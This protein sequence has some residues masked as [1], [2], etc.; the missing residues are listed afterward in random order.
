MLGMHSFSRFP[1][2]AGPTGLD[3]VS[4]QDGC[5]FQDHQPRQEHCLPRLDCQRHRLHLLSFG[6]SS[7]WICEYSYQ[8]RVSTSYLPILILMSSTKPLICN[9]TG[10]GKSWLNPPTTELTLLDHQEPPMPGTR[11]VTLDV[12]VLI[13]PDN[14]DNIRQSNIDD[15]TIAGRTELD[16]LPG[17]N[18]ASALLRPQLA[19]SSQLWRNG[20]HLRPRTDSRIRRSGSS[21]GRNRKTLHVR[22]LQ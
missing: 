10:A 4:N 17:R 18:P 6:K 2:A 19:G 16:H 15:M 22:D 3:D 14:I 9:C 21:V 12:A 20:S 5:L 7:L 8:L 11:L 13:C 1:I